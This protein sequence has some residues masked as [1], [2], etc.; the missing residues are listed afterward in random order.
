[1]YIRHFGFSE[2]PFRLLPDPAYLFMG[3]SHREAM[4]HLAYAVE[5]GDGFATVIGEV[6]TGK[7]TLCRAFLESLGEDVASIYIFN[8]ATDPVDLLRSINRDLDL[9]HDY[10]NL[11]DLIEVLNAFLIRENAGG[12][13]VVLIIDEAQNLSRQVLEQIRLLSNLE[14]ARAKLLQII[15]VGQ[16]ELQ[17]TLSVPQLRQLRQRITLSCRIV[18]LS[19]TE[20]GAYIRHRLSV[21]APSGPVRFSS[22]AVHAIYRYSGGIPRLIN[23]ACD[24]ALLTAYGASRQD[25]DRATAV[26]AVAELRSSAAPAGHSSRPMRWLTGAAM[27]VLIIAGATGLGRMLSGANRSDSG[28]ALPPKPPHQAPPAVENAKPAPLPPAV[29]IESPAPLPP[30]PGDSW[31]LDRIDALNLVLGAWGLP[32]QPRDPSM[33]DD[34][35]FFRRCTE[36][37]GLAV[38][39][40]DRRPNLVAT[41]NLPAVLPL[42]KS[43]GETKGYAAL[44]AMKDERYGVERADGKGPQFVEAPALGRQWSGTAYVFWKDVYRL[45]GEIPGSAGGETVLTLKLLLRELGYAAVGLDPVFDAET[46]RAVVDF[47]IR[48]GLPADGVVGSMTKIAL[49]NTRPGLGIPKL[50]PLHLPPEEDVPTGDAP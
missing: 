29:D 41:L 38:Y 46:R 42:A 21:A 50:H 32:P 27:A 45:Q 48:Q 39:R 33:T 44:V 1:M 8:P 13:T 14:T 23:T 25:V 40:V 22:A 2:R 31:R 19:P 3:R 10:Q 36:P 26:S 49:V 12:R 17:E 11:Q 37:L 43:D 28:P 24:R 20:T 16:P 18:P 5:S 30:R 6:G 47:Q 4:A 7:T 35:A 9:P 34:E 15:L